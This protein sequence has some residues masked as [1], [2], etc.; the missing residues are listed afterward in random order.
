MLELKIKPKDIDGITPYL[1][2]KWYCGDQA[3]LRYVEYHRRPLKIIE[4]IDHSPGMRILDIG[5]DWGYL[6][7]YIQDHFQN[8][9]CHGI[10]ICNEHI[11]FGNTIAKYNGYNIYLEY[12][13]ANN[14]RYENAFFDYVVSTETFEH[15]FHLNV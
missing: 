13:N 2:G 5:C 12:G 11:G 14:L 3:V 1:Y 4:N 8:V 6:L 7:M 15:F 10:D 9:F